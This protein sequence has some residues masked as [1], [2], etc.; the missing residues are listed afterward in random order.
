MDAFLWSVN[1]IVDFF[2][3]VLAIV[4]GNVILATIVLCGVVSLV[5]GSL[6]GSYRK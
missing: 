5:V 3:D 6:K 2:A 1:F 4:F